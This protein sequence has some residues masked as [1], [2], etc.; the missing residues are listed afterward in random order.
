M[1][2][3]RAENAAS[4]VDGVRVTLV[5]SQHWSQ[6]GPFDRNDTLWGGFV[7]SA[8]ERISVLDFE[9][10]LAPSAALSGRD[11]F[12]P[13]PQAATAWT[14]SRMISNSARA[15]SGT[16]KATASAVAARTSD[17]SRNSPMPALWQA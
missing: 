14:S 4:V 16:D 1:L 11:F 6:R 7:A 13:G 17:S 15:T 10:R 3:P 2:A 12:I 8:G 5:P 9:Q